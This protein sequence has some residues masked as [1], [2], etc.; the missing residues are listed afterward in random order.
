MLVIGC[1]A[2]GQFGVKILRLMT[3]A[4]IIAVDLERYFGFRVTIIS[5]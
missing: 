3:G 4:E 1:G 2:L 5:W